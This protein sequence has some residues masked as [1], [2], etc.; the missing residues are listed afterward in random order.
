MITQYTPKMIKA[1]KFA[2]KVHEI[3]QKQK[4]KGKDISYITHPLTVALILSQINAS[5]EV[6]IAGLLH[7]TVEDCSEDYPVTLQDITK[8]FGQEI[9]ELVESVTEKERDLPWEERKKQALRHIKKFSHDMTLLKSADVLSNGT[10]IIDD[11]KEFGEEVFE[12]FNAP[13]TDKIKSQIYLIIALLQ[14]W[15]ESPLANDLTVLLHEFFKLLGINFSQEQI[16]SNFESP[17]M[18]ISARANFA[19]YNRKIHNLSPA[20]QKELYTDKEVAHKLNSNIQEIY[21]YIKDKKLKAKKT[22]NGY[23][24]TDKNYNIFLKKYGHEKPTGY[25]V[26]FI[27][28]LS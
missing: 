5:E 27:K 17:K 3:D 9:S 1:I 2:T 28:S 16:S 7:D 23:E 11:Y 21:V 14:Q 20:P 24:I 18:S 13:K 12:R 19:S 26:D 8:K 22:K 4:R 25:S 6:I 15:E 10:E